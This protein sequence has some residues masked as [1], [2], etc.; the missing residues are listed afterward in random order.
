MNLTKSQLGNLDLGH[1]RC[2][3]WSYYTSV[4]SPR[5]TEMAKKSEITVAAKA[6]ARVVSHILDYPG[7]FM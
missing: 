7:F 3:R 1:L 4:T 5:R 2:S 6:S